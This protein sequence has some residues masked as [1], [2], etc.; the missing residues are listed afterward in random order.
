MA[1]LPE[2]PVVVITGASAGLGR[3][4]A[5]GYAKKGARLALL[6]RNPEA[7]EAAVNECL[8]LGSPQ[9]I[10]IPTDVSDAGAVEAAATRAEQELG[11]S[12]S[13]STTR[14]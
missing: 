10:S 1:H 7:L 9:A 4:I 11:P 8:L 2:H 12:M 13:G 5:H 3:A 6:A 14:W